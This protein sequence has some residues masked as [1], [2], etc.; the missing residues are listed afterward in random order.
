MSNVLLLNTGTSEFV[1]CTFEE[2]F[3]YPKEYGFI[4]CVNDDF[5]LSEVPSIG[6]YLP[7]MIPESI[8]ILE[9]YRPEV[10]V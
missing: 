1:L 10:L 7:S 2:M 8:E 5:I 4:L 3:S 9:K 6:E